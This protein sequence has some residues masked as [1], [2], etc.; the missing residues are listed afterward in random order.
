[1]CWDHYSTHWCGASDISTRLQ[2]LVISVCRICLAKSRA[3]KS[4]CWKAEVAVRCLLLRLAP[5]YLFIYCCFI[6]WLANRCCLRWRVEDELKQR[7]GRWVYGPKV[8]YLSHAGF[9]FYYCLVACVC[10]C[11]MVSDCFARRSRYFCA[12]RRK[13]K[14]HKTSD[15]WTLTGSTCLSTW[16]G[17]TRCGVYIVTR[18]VIGEMG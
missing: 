3:N 18:M 4:S 8:I 12:K 6:D 9:S 11:I 14:A 5:I 10:A 17:S 13:I 2:I 16:R 7:G 15:Y 1:M